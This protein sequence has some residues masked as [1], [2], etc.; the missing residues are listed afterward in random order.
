[1][2]DSRSED[3]VLQAIRIA[4][5]GHRTRSQGPHL[6]KAPKGEDR[7]YYFVHLAE[8]AWILSDAGCDRELIA[9]GYLHDLIEDCGYT[10]EQLEQE[11]GNKRVVMLVEAVSEPGSLDDTGKKKS[12]EKRNANYLDSMVKAPADV[13]TLSCVDKTANLMEMCHW[14]DRGYQTEEFTSRDHATQL[15]KFD[16]LDQVYQGKVADR[17]YTRFVDWLEIFRRLAPGS[18]EQERGQLLKRRDFKERTD[19][20]MGGLLQ[21][22]NEGALADEA[23]R[24]A[25][26]Q[27]KQAEK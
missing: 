15:A 23:R 21:N 27:E 17:P 11:I 3:I 25:E 1:M 22:L 16:A 2:N 14:L 6:R 9:A 18:R 13:L 20:I 5:K 24:K 7:P 26:S 19:R 4:E 12:W 10:G 8:V